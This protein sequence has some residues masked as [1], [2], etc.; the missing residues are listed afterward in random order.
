MSSW[1]A[2]ALPRTVATP[3]RVVSRTAAAASSQEDSIPRISIAGGVSR[4]GGHCKSDRVSSPVWRAGP[5]G[6]PAER[7]LSES[8]RILS[9]PGPRKTQ[10]SDG[11]G[12]ESGGGGGGEAAGGAGMGPPAG[13]GSSAPA[14]GA[15]SGEESDG[16]RR[17]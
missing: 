2:T 4:K 9:A 15:P 5:P 6:G 7:R 1:L 17:V 8:F 10:S 11:G 14:A 3:A 16:A 13:G 12:G